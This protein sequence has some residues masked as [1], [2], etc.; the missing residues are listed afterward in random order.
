LSTGSATGAALVFT[1]AGVLAGP[2]AFT[3]LHG[4]IGS[5]TTTFG[6]MAALPA[7]GFLLLLLAR[8]AAAERGQPK[9]HA[10]PD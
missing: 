6:L 10:G 3:L 4:V 8:R 5:F 7:A 9:P 1:F 2:P